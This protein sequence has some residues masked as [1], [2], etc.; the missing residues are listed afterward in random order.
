MVNADPVIDIKGRLSIE[1]V[2]RP[3]V[4]LKQA[5]RSLKGLCPWH[6]EK[7]PSFVVSPERQLAYCFGCS[8]GGDMFSFIQEIEGVDFKGAIELLAERAGLDLSHYER[9]MSTPKVTKDHKDELFRANEEAAKFFQEY[10]MSTKEGKKV[11]QYLED[12]GMTAETVR[13]FGL[14]LSPDSF[15]ET[16]NYLVQ[17]K[18]SMSE[19]LEVGLV[20]SQS[21]TLDKTYDKFRCRLMFPILNVQGKIAVFGGRALKK[22]D[23]PKYMNSPESPIYHKGDILYGFYRAKKA[24]REHDLAV[25]VEGYMDVMASHQAGVE[26]VVASSGTALTDA[27]L[28]L[29]K[30]FTNNV[31]FSF[32][33]DVA[34]EEALRRAIDIGQPLGIMM[35]VIRVPNG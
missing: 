11:L 35:K 5:G 23:Q 24:I 3:Y 33:T 26:H 25:V 9:S 10:L 18:C 27:Q 30:R 2:V 28:K 17:K 14:G 32:D 7:T 21:T 6:S 15:D 8:K 13:R 34:G 19:L 12:R 16:L 22:D 4:Q 1:D 31:A 20:S 29:L